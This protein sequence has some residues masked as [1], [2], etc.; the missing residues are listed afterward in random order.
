MLGQILRDEYALC[1]TP[2][3]FRFYAHIGVLH[4][5]EDFGCLNVSHITGSSAGALIG[6]F[7]AAGEVLFAYSTIII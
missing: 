2:G 7:L 3:F 6:V 4:A 5:L 1:L